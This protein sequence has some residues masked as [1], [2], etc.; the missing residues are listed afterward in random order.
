MR[1]L[2]AAERSHAFV[3]VCALLSLMVGGLSAVLFHAQVTPHLRG[4]LI[5]HAPEVELVIEHEGCRV[6]RAL[7]SDR[8]RV[9]WSTCRGQ[10]Q[11]RDGFGTRGRF[12]V[13][14][15]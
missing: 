5:E 3:I 2:E 10:T 7:D 15:H 13:N 11:W 9:Y 12:V 14:D 6:W 8:N 1:L 4:P